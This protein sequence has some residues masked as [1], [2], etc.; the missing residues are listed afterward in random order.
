MVIA[1]S[2][3]QQ[4]TLIGKLGR[5]CDEHQLTPIAS[6][7]LDL[8]DFLSQDLARVER[9]LDAIKIPDDVTGKSAKHL[10]DLPGK[11]LR[12][13][14][15]ALAARTQDG[16]NEAALN[17]GVAVELVHSATLLHDDVVDLGS[18]RRNQPCA[19]LI[20][21]N[22][23]SI[24]GGDWLLVEAL[25]RVLASK[26][27]GALE[28]VLQVIERMIEAEAAQLEA[29][30]H[31]NFDL[32]NYMKII[33][34]KTA[35]LFR[36]AMGAG[37]RAGNQTPAHCLALEEFGQNLGLA[38]QIVDD[39]LD[40]VGHEELTGKA[41]FADLREGKMTYPLIVGTQRSPD[42]ADRIKEYLRT[43]SSED[44]PLGIQRDIL[45]SLVAT[46]AVES[47]MTFA[48]ELSQQAKESLHRLPPSD[49]RT[50]L[51]LI[52]EVALHR[53]S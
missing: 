42:L 14:C 2:K 53:R 20:Y 32:E 4:H 34:G 3:P 12:P 46:G 30:G 26:L 10:L 43:S 19:R 29:R 51:E 49:A 24:F 15:V 16:F 36:W 37:G 50:A 38:F 21:G 23:A 31:L 35:A 33:E 27:D 6:T 52:S 8:Q 22:A 9:T 44:M 11:R 7:L 40:L 48:K 18:S 45:N 28:E 41:L 13:L 5:L 1:S 39:T 47:S 17:I 25:R